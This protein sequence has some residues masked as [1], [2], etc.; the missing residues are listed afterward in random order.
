MGRLQSFGSQA[1]DVSMAGGTMLSGSAADETDLVIAKGRML[2]CATTVAP[3]GVLLLTQTELRCVGPPP[4]KPVLWAAS[5][6]NLL[7]VQQRGSHVRL[8]ALAE[9]EGGGSGGGGDGDVGGG[10][11]RAVGGSQSATVSH[12]VALHS[13]DEAVRLH[14]VLRLAGL[15]AKGVALPPPCA[16]PLMRTT[17]LEVLRA[18]DVESAAWR[19][20]P[21]DAMN[22]E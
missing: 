17:L 21:D 9:R 5:L 12:E 16:H 2:L 1:G 19:V 11:G 13:D 15:N 14:E 22:S 7:L 6:A 4:G 8:I 3:R 10:G 18:E 20:G